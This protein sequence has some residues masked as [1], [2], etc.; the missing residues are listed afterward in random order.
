MM[1][2]NYDLA[3]LFN[4]FHPEIVKIINKTPKDNIIFS[5]IK[6]LQPINQWQKGKVCLVG[7]AA[8]ATTPN[9]GQGA[10][11]AIEDA[12]VIGKLFGQEKSVEAVFTQYEKLRLEK[13]H[14]IINTSWTIGKV[15]HYE[16]SIAIWV[17]NFLVKNTPINIVEKQLNKVFSIEYNIV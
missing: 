5:D 6:D 9:M 7:D 2:E 12:Y 11:Q 14:Y 10:C 8:H 13:A 16:N 4:E 17:R 15:A 1:K 3:D